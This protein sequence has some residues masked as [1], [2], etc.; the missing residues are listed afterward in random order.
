[1]I[2]FMSFTDLL[3]MG[4]HGG[5]V[6]SAYGLSIFLM[7]LNVVLIF[8]S[9]R[10]YLDQLSRR[11]KKG[12]VMMNPIRKKRLG[13]IFLLVCGVS[14]ALGL[15]LTALQENI[16]LFFSPSEIVSGKVPEGIFIR[17]G[18]LVEKGSLKRSMDS[19]ELQ[20]SITDGSR[21]IIV[22]Y[23]GILPDLFREGQGVVAL[24]KLSQNKVLQADQ[25]LAKHDENYM[26]PE[27]AHAL[28]EASAADH[29]KQLVKEKRK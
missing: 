26:P 25:I 12:C 2:T 3:S 14:T 15:A 5:Y 21:N 27:A 6:W 9:R 22:K 8:I 4:G 29:L 23:K 17:A 19:L 28:K 16:N 11:K 13:K 24:G 10:R 7:L 1:M 18:G 20:F